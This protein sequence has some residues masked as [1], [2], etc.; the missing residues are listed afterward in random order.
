MTYLVTYYLLA[1]R[2]RGSF[3]ARFQK[4][5]QFAVD[6]ETCGAAD[7]KARVVLADAV[8]YG[9]RHGG[10][11][12]NVHVHIASVLPTTPKGPEWEDVVRECQ[13]N[14]EE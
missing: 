12:E 4:H 2:D 13:R 9:V 14:K 6:A 11:P 10:M 5:G 3:S 1:H 7:T 8:E